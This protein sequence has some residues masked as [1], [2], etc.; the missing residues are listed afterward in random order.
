VTLLSTC[1]RQSNTKY[2]SSDFGIG[3]GTPVQ[4]NGDDY[5]ILKKNVKFRKGTGGKVAFGFKQPNSISSSVVRSPACEMKSVTEND[6][7]VE[8]QSRSGAI[9]SH[10]L[11]DQVPMAALRFERPQA[12]DHS[13]LGVLQIGKTKLCFQPSMPALEFALHG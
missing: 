3:V 9:P 12:Y 8:R 7:L 6:R 13:D 10:K 1:K 11:I 5:S 2:R 4:T